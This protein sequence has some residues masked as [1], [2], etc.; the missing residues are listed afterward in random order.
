MSQSR[1]DA[2]TEVFVNIS[3]GSVVAWAITY[4]IMVNVKN[5]AMASMLSVGCC[6]VASFIRGY[7][8]RRHFN[9]LGNKKPKVG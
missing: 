9:H 8:V 2:L 5:P 1:K 7:W 3:I 6:T 4:V